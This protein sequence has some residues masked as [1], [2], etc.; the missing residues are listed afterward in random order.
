MKELFF[1]KGSLADKIT[2]YHLLFFVMSLPFDRLYSELALISLAVHT[3]IHLRKEAIRQVKWAT[4][5]L[6]CSIYLLTVIGT[7]YTRFYDEAFYEW[8]R[9]LAIILFPLIIVFNSF[10][11]RKYRFHIVLGLAVS[12]CLLILY[13]YYVAFGVIRYNHMPLSAVFSNAFINHR[14][15]APINMHATYFSMYIALGAVG[16]L[17]GMVKEEKNKWLYGL[18]FLVLLAGLLQ[19]SSRAVLIAFAIIGNLVVP[20]TIFQGRR[21]TQFMILSAFISLIIFFGITQMDDLKTRMITDLKDELTESGLNVNTVEPRIRRWESAWQLIKQSPAY[22]YGSGSE[23][24]LLKE[25]YYRGKLY[26]SYLH[27]LN[28]H[29]QYLSM[30]IKTGIPGLCVLLFLFF[31]GFRYVFRS[32]EI[33]F[34][35][36]LVII[37]SVSFSENVMDA[38]KGIFF[39]SCFFSLFY[40][41]G[42]KKAGDLFEN[43]IVAINT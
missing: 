7:A 37:C 41:G 39:F 38:N 2:Y 35:S 28:A 10:D 5:L 20:L 43:E 19:L 14:F 36:F 29:N 21:R 15:S 17:S 30:L 16:M 32:R 1:I 11:F 22:G 12:C 8:E 6:P 24:A 27:E 4:L 42:K 31:S 40:L 9:Q 18:I 13:L 33:L 34:G 23:I 26:H 25:A 3:L